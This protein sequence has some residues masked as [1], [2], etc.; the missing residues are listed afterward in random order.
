MCMCVCVCI[1]KLSQLFS[2]PQLEVMEGKRR[3]ERSY[4]AGT[5]VTFLESVFVG[6]LV[7]PLLRTSA[8]CSLEMGDTAIPGHGVV[9]SAGSCCPH[10]HL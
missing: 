5:V 6:F 2:P 8:C 9:P 1:Y 7:I 4:Q 10:R 3:Q